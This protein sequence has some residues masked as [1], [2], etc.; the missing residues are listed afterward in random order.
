MLNKGCFSD[1]DIRNMELR[2]EAYR[3]QVAFVEITHSRVGIRSIS[4]ETE[5]SAMRLIGNAK[6]QIY[7]M[8]YSKL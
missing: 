5:N 6:H 1:E 3:R 8:I 2:T 4:N 7:N